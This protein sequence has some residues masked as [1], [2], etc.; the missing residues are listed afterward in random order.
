MSSLY[1][2]VLRASSSR[3]NGDKILEGH[4]FEEETARIVYLHEK[5]AGIKANQ[6]RLTLQMPTVSGLSYQ[7]DASFSFR[8]TL[9]VVECKKRKS[10]LTG[11]ELVHYFVSKILDY[12]LAVEGS[13]KA[14][15]LRGIFLS[16][17]DAGDSGFTFGLSFGVRVID[18]VHPPVE[19]ML[20]NLPTGETA[21]MQSLSELS[22]RMNMDFIHNRRASPNDL[23]KQ[24]K[25]L[26]SRWRNSAQPPRV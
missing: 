23:Y 18:P 21:L 11:S 3:S 25:F 17:Q 12:V 22:D 6:P 7:F 8:D 5:S 16:T 20:S 15:Q 9:Y 13:G 19:Y 26:Q 4:E 10:M 2:L 1:E 24:Y 14:V